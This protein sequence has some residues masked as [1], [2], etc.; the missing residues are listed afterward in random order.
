MS[1]IERMRAW[2]DDLAGACLAAHEAI[3]VGFVRKASEILADALARLD[4][5]ERAK[6]GGPEGEIDRL[7]AQQDEM[8]AACRGLVEMWDA[9]DCW[10]GY[11]GDV[12]HFDRRV[13]A[14]RNILERLDAGEPAAPPRF[15]VGVAIDHESGVLHTYAT[16][17]GYEA[18]KS[19]DARL[20]AARVAAWQHHP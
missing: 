12:P 19:E 17:A 5:G 18:T 2:R 15:V 4:A 6:K 20:Y 14:V 16:E 1:E 9:P 11:E 7:K 13:E 3:D 8:A 10:E